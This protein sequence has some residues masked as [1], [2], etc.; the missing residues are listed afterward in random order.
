MQRTRAVIRRGAPYTAIISNPPTGRELV[1]RFLLRIQ[2]VLDAK[3]NRR[4]TSITS[5]TTRSERRLRNVSARC[6]RLAIAA[7][8]IGARGLPIAAH[9]DTVRCGAGGGSDDAQRWTPARACD[10]NRARCDLRGAV[11]RGGDGA[12]AS[13]VAARRVVVRAADGADCAGVQEA[14]SYTAREIAARSSP[15]VPPPESIRTPADLAEL[16]AR[17]GEAHL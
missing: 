7:S 8:T 4:R 3:S 2:R 6:V 9:G 11:V 15:G 17:I 16:V 5:T 13:G 14:V 10:R 1:Q 12:G